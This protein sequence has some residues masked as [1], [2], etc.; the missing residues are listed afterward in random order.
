MKEQYN[1]ILKILLIGSSHVGKSSLLVRF[2]DDKYNE[3]YVSTIGVD[4]KLKT[5]AIDNELVKV[6]IWDTAGQ[7]RFKAITTS[8]YKN[9][10]G[11]IIAYDVTDRNSFVSI[12]HWMDEIER[13]AVKGI[14][15]IVIGNK[16][17]LESKRGVSYKEGEEIAKKYHAE[18]YETSAKTAENVSEVFEKMT[19]EIIK[20]VK[21]QM[22]TA[23]NSKDA[24]VSK[25]KKLEPTNKKK[26]SGCC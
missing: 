9:A 8:Y 22:L 24:Q 17:D 4:F 5:M 7:E 21:K 13:L 14:P 3:Y 19:R 25:G 20:N 18:F 10:H 16:T 26:N 11:I 1:Y 15:K 6:Q 23:S 12:R 2:C